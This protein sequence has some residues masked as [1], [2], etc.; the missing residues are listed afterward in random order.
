[1]QRNNNMICDIGLILITNN[2]FD[3][4]IFDNCTNND[5]DT[6]VLI[7]IYFNNIIYKPFNENMV[8]KYQF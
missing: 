5:S 3:S 8:S 2:I 1:M 4:Y 6:I 7:F